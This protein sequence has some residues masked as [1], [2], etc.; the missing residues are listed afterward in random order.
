[1]EIYKNRKIT[2]QILQEKQ[3]SAE[4][5]RI[6]VVN[7]IKVYIKDIPFPIKGMPT[8]EALGAVN[9]TKRILIEWVKSTPL[10]AFPFININKLT[11]SFNRLSWAV[12]SPYIL[13]EEYKQTFTQEF[14]C[15]VDNFLKKIGV[16][17][18]IQI[19]DTIS[20]IFEYDSA[21]RLRIQD[22]LSETSK[23]KL[24]NSPIRE[25][26]RLSNLS[27]QRDHEYV[28]KN[29]R[30]I[31]ILLSIML[32]IPKYRRAFKYAIMSSDFERLQFDKCDRYWASLRRDYKSYGL[33]YD[34][35]VEQL[36]FLGYKI[37]NFQ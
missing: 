20:H 28:Y 6:E 12:M 2:E 32:I 36:K 11:S 26:M 29:V 18:S 7:G 14:S 15:L 22:L 10:V 1:M 5:D 21:Y 35:R 16:E 37:P 25:I 9:I 13:K 31:K 19:A 27:K 30:I 4:V 3:E 23:V 8:A 24:H 17:E 33:E 34:E